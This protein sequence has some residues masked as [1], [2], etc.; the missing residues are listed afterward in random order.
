MASTTRYEITPY[1]FKVRR[2]DWPRSRNL[3]FF[4]K[5][6]R[7]GGPPWSEDVFGAIP[8]RLSSGDSEVNAGANVQYDAWDRIDRGGMGAELAGDKTRYRF[9]TAYAGD[10]REIYPQPATSQPT[11]VNGKFP[12][13]TGAAACLPHVAFSQVLEA[14]ST[15]RFRITPGANFALGAPVEVSFSTATAAIAAGSSTLTSATDVWLA[16]DVGLPISVVGAG[17]DGA[18]LQ[19]TIAAFTNARTVTLATIATDAVSAASAR[20][21]QARRIVVIDGTNN[22]WLTV[23]PLIP[24]LV[25]QVA[26]HP[27]TTEAWTNQQEIRDLLVWRVPAAVPAALKAPDFAPIVTA[28]AKLPANGNI[29]PNDRFYICFT[30]QTPWGESEHSLQTEF[31]FGATPHEIKIQFGSNS[32]DVTENGILYRAN[33]KDYPGVTGYTIYGYRPEDSATFNE[34]NLKVVATVGVRS[35]QQVKTPLPRHVYKAE[36]TNEGRPPEYTATRSPSAFSCILVVSCDERWTYLNC[37]NLRGATTSTIQPMQLIRDAAPQQVVTRLPGT[38]EPSSC[39][40][41]LSQIVVPTTSPDGTQPMVRVW[42]DSSLA[43]D[44]AGFEH[45]LRYRE[46]TGILGQLA[47]AESSRRL[48]RVYR[49]LAYWSADPFGGDPDWTGPTAIGPTDYDVLQMIAY[50]GAKNSSDSAMYFTKPDGLYRILDTQSGPGNRAEWLTT[51]GVADVRYGRPLVEHRGELYIGAGEHILRYTIA[52]VDLTGPN[53]DGGLPQ[54]LRSALSGGAASTSRHLYVGGG[55]DR[56]GDGMGRYRQILETEQ[57][58]A[59]HQVWS[60][61]PP[62]AFFQSEL[63]QGPPTDISSPAPLLVIVPP[64]L[65]GTPESSAGRTTLV[66]TTGQHAFVGFFPLRHASERLREAPG[67]LPRT[68]LVQIDLPIFFGG[69]RYIEK[70]WHWLQ[71][72]QSSR[73]RPAV[74]SYI[75]MD[76]TPWQPSY[77]DQPVYDVSRRI[78]LDPTGTDAKWLLVDDTG[79]IYTHEFF[80][81]EITGMRQ[82][83]VVRSEGISI[84]LWLHQQPATAASQTLVME[85]A[86]LTSSDVSVALGRWVFSCE[87]AL[88]TTATS[89]RQAANAQEPPLADGELPPAGAH[90]KTIVEFYEA[91]DQLTELARNSTP[92]VLTD[93]TGLEHICRMDL[94]R[95]IPRAW[96]NSY[97]DTGEAAVLPKQVSF[98]VTFTEL[99]NIDDTSNVLQAG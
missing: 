1:G 4:V 22:E 28:G 39:T 58:E 6:S 50:G 8:S 37:L 30:K 96:Y 51:F 27:T 56:G 13:W 97:L 92:L 33:T 73:T 69:S 74:G 59:W 88:Q 25:A 2:I 89:R 78:S 80:R 75:G 11:R 70:I 45:H 12:S 57:G 95:R 82:Q 21:Y 49:N 85:E 71:W 84:R 23:D 81:Q 31:Q 98:D 63:G 17:D 40:I 64:D 43:D 93:A 91:Y 62:D 46:M 72:A 77:T 38:I 32:A 54:S 18:E 87:L 10:P 15:T 34:D 67:Y 29:S 24:D 36:A 79:R 3:G 16:T 14:S 9:A 42:Y 76:I 53:R 47:Y 83:H 26:A 48:W 94:G 65:H 5:S 44:P 99:Y 68:G 90:Y 35:N 55:A 19:T 7:Q 52:N 61:T 60:S 20:W 66:Y 86:V 41:W